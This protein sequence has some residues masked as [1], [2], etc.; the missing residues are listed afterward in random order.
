MAKYIPAKGDFVI[1]T[2][3]P[4][5]GHEQMG[6]R[7]ALVISNSTFN[8]HTG[9]CVA[10]P[11][12]STDRN[13]PFHLPIPSGCG[14]QGIVMADQLKSLDFRARK[15]QFME[16]APLEVLKDVLAVIEAIIYQ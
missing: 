8:R 11:I 13:I 15:V 9:L 14:I 5:T 4:Q 1:L 6:R 2:F 12:T 3:D 10:C 7:P 16:K